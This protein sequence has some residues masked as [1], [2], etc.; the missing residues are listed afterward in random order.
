M[1]LS[2]KEIIEKIKRYLKT[3]A[4]KVEN[5]PDGISRN[6]AENWLSNEYMERA[7]KEIII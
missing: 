4:K 3:E 2:D 6:A 1:N 7:E 5:Y